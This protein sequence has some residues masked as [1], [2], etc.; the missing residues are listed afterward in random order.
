VTPPGSD[1]APTRTVPP[2]GTGPHSTVG[3][4]KPGAGA[5]RGTAA[6]NDFTIPNKVSCELGGTVSLTAI[7]DTDGASAVVFVLDGDTVKGSP[8][9]SGSFDLDIPCDGDAHT[10]VL[11]A[12][13]DDG[14]TTVASKAILTNVAPVGD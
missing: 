5:G 11:T 9:T 8:R 14:G 12:L 7:Y 6:I 2:A 10:L 4:T 13:D 3:T 1:V